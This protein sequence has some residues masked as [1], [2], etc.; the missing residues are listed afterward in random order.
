MTERGRVQR[1]LRVVYLC[2]MNRQGISLGI[3]LVGGWW[4]SVMI[5]S[6]FLSLSLPLSLDFG[7]CNE[8]RGNGLLC[9]AWLTLRSGLHEGGVCQGGLLYGMVVVMKVHGWTVSFLFP[10]E[11]R[12]DFSLFSSGGI[13]WPWGMMSCLFASQRNQSG[14][15]C[16]P[17]PV[18]VHS[19]LNMCRFA[20][21]NCRCVSD[22]GV[23]NSAVDNGMAWWI[24]TF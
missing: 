5:L 13:H 8:V 20:C 1:W 9:V 18:K 16:I 24:Y 17:H 6:V 21:Q 22:P 2:L 23:T 15:V 3:R 4:H 10:A 19:T 11:R 14:H 7:W 12:G